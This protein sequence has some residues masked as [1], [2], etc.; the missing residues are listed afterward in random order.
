MRF[1]KMQG[2]GNDYVYVN[3]F[4]EPFPANPAALAQKIADRHFGVGGDGLIL[5]CPSDTADARMRMFNAD[6][7]ESEM[8]GNGV[9]CVAKYVYD[10]GLS[11]KETL[12]I[13]TGR[14]VL[15]LEVHVIDGLVERVRVDMGQPI[16]NAADI[17]TTLPGNPVVRKR[18]PVAGHDLDVTCVSMGNPHCV[19]YVDRLSDEW[20][21]GIGPKIET[22]PHFPRRVNAEF[23]EVISPREVRMRVWERGSGETLACGTGASAVCVAGVLAGMTE[24]SILA[25][26]PGG[27]LELEWAANDHVYMTGPAVEVFSG[28]WMPARDEAPLAGTA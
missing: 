6:G 24:R 12:R 25:H 23:V 5:I 16:L 22:D 14:G 11:N 20:V 21:L 2:A 4:A 26:L 1:T 15:T 3:C 19:T 7:S 28:E 9:R 8:C 18:L 17:P 13:E 10:H 27:D